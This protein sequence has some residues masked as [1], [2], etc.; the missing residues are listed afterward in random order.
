ME[1][2]IVRRPLQ[3]P[4]EGHPAVAD[5]SKAAAG[6]YSHEQTSIRLAAQA[7]NRAT[8]SATCTPSP[9]VLKVVAMQENIRRFYPGSLAD[10]FWRDSGLVYDSGT[11][12]PHLD[13]RLSG[14]LNCA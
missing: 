11:L 3:R 2:G 1:R 8:V 14:S 4:M 9:D 6:R 12:P 7:A 10:Y 13:P 5:L